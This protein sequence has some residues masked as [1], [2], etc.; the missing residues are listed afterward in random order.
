MIEISKFDGLS[1]YFLQK[2]FDCEN[3]IINSFV[4]K[5]LTPQVKKGLC[6]AYVLIDSSHQDRFVG[7]YTIVQHAINVSL[8][9]SLN[10]GSL[11]S[12]IPCSRV[13]M[14]GVDKHYKN[15]KLGQMLLKHA[16][17]LT[18]TVASQI[19]SY[20]LYLDADKSAIDFYKKYG[21]S[22]LENTMPSGAV[23]MFIP[24]NKIY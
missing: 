13:V 9:N 12:T 17:S 4:H 2:K 10:L 16:L 19:G 24:V 15:K 20:G 1:P 6:T 23:S 21:F 5:S 7:F 18:K 8:I 14:L 11:P 22:L 3:Q